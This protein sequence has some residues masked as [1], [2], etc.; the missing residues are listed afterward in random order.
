V[1]AWFP[2]VWWAGP[3][4]ACVLGSVSDILYVILVSAGLHLGSFPPPPTFSKF[5]LR[6]LVQDVN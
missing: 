6:I 5:A 4:R 1:A 3:V 2:N